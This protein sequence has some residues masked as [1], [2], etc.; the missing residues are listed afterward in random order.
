MDT[1]DD[2]SLQVEL[3]RAVRRW[4]RPTTPE[5]LAARGVERV[6]SVSLS[7]VAALLEKAVN[8]TLIRRTLEGAPEDA[9]SLSSAAREEFVRLARGQSSSDTTW[10]QERAT[11]AL[12]RL[13]VELA[14][15]REALARDAKVNHTVH[16]LREAAAVEERLR[17]LFAR[18]AAAQPIPV[19]LER[20]VLAVVAAAF[21]EVQ[22][23]ARDAR[24]REHRR[25]LDLLERRVA[26]LQALLAES[27]AELARARTPGEAGLASVYDR[28]Q[29]LASA[30][31]QRERKGALM[32]ALFAANLE[33]NARRS[34]ADFPAATAPS[35]S[36]PSR[37]SSR[38]AP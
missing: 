4:A 2:P 3:T 9:L 36:S 6:H 29:G 23:R 13:R 16:D 18:H 8:R 14:R 12:A 27:E 37:S 24:Q 5:E 33:L 17:A 1:A 19:A 7:R 11:G 31:P 20:E 10:V 30:D 34:E 21:D 38:N 25:E 22:G 32:A 28:V 26:K 15:R 35:S